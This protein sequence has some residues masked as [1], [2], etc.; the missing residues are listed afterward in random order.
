MAFIITKNFITG[1]TYDLKDRSAVTGPQSLMLNT[2]QR[3]RDG[4]GDAFVILNDDD[5]IL[6]EGFYIEDAEAEETGD[7][8]DDLQP[9]NDYA[10]N[11]S[12]ASDIKYL[13][14]EGNWI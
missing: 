10:R 7:D 1:V 5:K 2:E 14:F 4:D 8:G 12:D 3:L 13:D 6:F 9:L 11:V